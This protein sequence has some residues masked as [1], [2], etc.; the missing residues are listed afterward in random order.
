[1]LLSLREQAH[2][3]RTKYYPFN[4]LILIFKT[5]NTMKNFINRAFMAKKK[6]IVTLICMLF[7][8]T[9]FGSER[10]LYKMVMT[11]NTALNV[12]KGS[13]ATLTSEHAHFIGKS[14]EVHNANSGDGSENHV[15]S[16]K[17]R[18]LREGDYLHVQLDKPLRIG[19]VIVITD[20]QGDVHDFFV[21][22]TATRE[23]GNEIIAGA[24]P[25]PLTIGAENTLIGAEDL[26]FWWGDDVVS[27]EGKNNRRYFKTITITTTNPE[28]VYYDFEDETVETFAQQ[29]EVTLVNGLRVNSDLGSGRSGIEEQSV[30]GY[31]KV[32]NIAGSGI[33]RALKLNVTDPCDI[34]VWAIS[35][36]APDRSLYITDDSSDL[37]KYTLYTTTTDNKAKLKKSTFRFDGYGDDTEF[38][39]SPSNGGWKIVAIRVIYDKIRPVADLAISPNTTQSIESGRNGS[40]V[41]TVTTSSDVELV[42]TPGDGSDASWVNV[43]QDGSTF[44]VTGTALGVGNTYNMVVCQAASANYRAASV[45]VNITINGTNATITS[46]TGTISGGSKVWSATEGNITMIDGK[47]EDDDKCIRTTTIGFENGLLLASGHTFTITVPSNKVINKITFSGYSNTNDPDKAKAKVRD[48]NNTSD[49]SSV[50]PVY[51][52]ETPGSKTFTVNANSFRFDITN[53]NAIVNITLT[54]TDNSTYPVTINHGWASFCAPEDVELPAGVDAYIVNDRESDVLY[55]EN[56]NITKVPANTGILLYSETDGDYNLTATTGA[57]A[58]SSGFAGT[59]ARIA[60]PNTETTFSLYDNNGTIEFWNYT[61]AF[62]PANKAYLVYGGG[63]AGAPAKKLRVQVAPK[64][65]TAIDEVQTTK[66]QSTKRFENGQLVIIR[67]G[68]KYNVQGQIVK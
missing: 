38:I 56:A 65:P 35:A 51:N 26:Y 19:D 6:T 34:E 68:V 62:I 11:S 39:I 33:N 59:V 54:L 55:I 2:H 67:D 22:K 60:N 3:Q 48:A 17:I 24:S 57:E 61:G 28:V 44:T 52:S 13:E 18:L 1:M 12:T 47:T 49:V 42:Q 46:A 53:A 25:E 5:I 30:A 8:T 40:A 9:M 64:M 20:E 21:T 43:A 58:L 63:S 15:A 29:A 32:L 37:D 36:D 14:A 16:S 4:Y 7:A 23:S 50:F 66:A 45:N 27:G 41:F 10:V 31:T